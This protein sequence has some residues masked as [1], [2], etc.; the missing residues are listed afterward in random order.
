MPNPPQRWAERL[1]WIL[2]WLQESIMRKRYIVILFILTHYKPGR[3]RKIIVQN[4]SETT[5]GSSE[6][7]EMAEFEIPHLSR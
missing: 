7:T 6:K 2:S 3:T 5:A 1:L 4:E